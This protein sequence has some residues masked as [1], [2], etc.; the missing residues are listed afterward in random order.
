VK[1]DKTEAAYEYMPLEYRQTHSLEE[2][3]QSSFLNEVRITFGHPDTVVHISLN[4]HD[5][6]VFS[7]WYELPFPS[8]TGFYIEKIDDQWFFTGE[9]VYYVD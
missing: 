8:G 7:G 6:Q 2:F 1:Q 5:G 3:E 9:Y 4:G